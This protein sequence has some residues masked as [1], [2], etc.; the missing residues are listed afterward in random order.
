MP[1][2]S[3][4][5]ENTRTIALYEL[6]ILLGSNHLQQYL[7]FCTIWKIERGWLPE[8]TRKL[9]KA[10]GSFTDIYLCNFQFASYGQNPRGNVIC[11]LPFSGSSRIGQI[12]AIEGLNLEYI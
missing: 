1:C 8:I 4:V 12:S 9:T 6:L 11:W 7:L 2:L 10:R 3:I 5:G